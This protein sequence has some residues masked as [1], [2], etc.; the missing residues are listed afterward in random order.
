MGPSRDV[1]YVGVQ[2]LGFELVPGLKTR[3]PVDGCD[4]NTH[5]CL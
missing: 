1:S 5:D 3:L 4:I 2:D